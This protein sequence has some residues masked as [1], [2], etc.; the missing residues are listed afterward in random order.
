MRDL[1]VDAD[2]RSFDE[3]PSLIAVDQ[4]GLPGNAHR[5]HEEEVFE[6]LKLQVIRAVK[7]GSVLGQDVDRSPDE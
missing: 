1:P 2:W 6:E 5:W 4:A 3:S 7:R